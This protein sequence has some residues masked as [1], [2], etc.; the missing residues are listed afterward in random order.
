ME[1]FAAPNIIET[2]IKQIEMLDTL[3]SVKESV[4]YTATYKLREKVDKE[5]GDRGDYIDSWYR[6][7]HL[8]PFEHVPVDEEEI[9][10]LPLPPLFGSPQT[11]TLKLSYKPKKVANSCLYRDCSLFAPREDLT[12]VINNGFLFCSEHC[13]LFLYHM[14]FHEDETEVNKTL[15]E[16]ISER[17]ERLNTIFEPKDCIVKCYDGSKDKEY[18]ANVDLVDWD[19]C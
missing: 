17:N 1:N 12:S 14:H 10:P 4:T 5:Q 9:G 6:T 18:I 13:K 15:D 19:C 7:N 3:I 11:Y 8:Y 2:K 16:M